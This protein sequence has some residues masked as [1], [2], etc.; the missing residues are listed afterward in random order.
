M[1]DRPVGALGV[2]DSTR[3]A[4]ALLV[5]F[6][7]GTMAQCSD[8]SRARKNY[9]HT[10]EYTIFH[11]PPPPSSSYHFL[12]P[13]QHILHPPSIRLTSSIAPF[14]PFLH[15]LPTLST[16]LFVHHPDA[17]RCFRIG[18]LFR[19]VHVEKCV[20]GTALVSMSGP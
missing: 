14:P 2:L 13:T 18:L 4:I 10:L 6:A 11:P 8:V 5:P 17:P 3:L 7:L 19:S 9:E 20:K 16:T 1:S 15:P 12:Y